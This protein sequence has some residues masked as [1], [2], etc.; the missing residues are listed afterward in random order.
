MC[1]P[2]ALLFNHMSLTKPIAA[3]FM[4]V[5]SLACC[6]TLKMGAT[7]FS[8]K[9]VDIQRNTR[10]YMPEIELLNLVPLS[11]LKMESTGSSQTL[12]TT[13][14]ISRYHYEDLNR[15]RETGLKSLLFYGM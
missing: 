6:S 2:S 4:L 3:C 1:V 5:S 10:R 8:E 15:N 11:I 12:I 13:Y 7:G 9:L 14:Q